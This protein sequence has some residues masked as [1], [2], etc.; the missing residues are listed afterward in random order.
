MPLFRCQLPCSRGNRTAARSVGILNHTTMKV[1]ALS[2]S[3]VPLE[4]HSYP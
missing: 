2:Y 1:K 4:I 3:T